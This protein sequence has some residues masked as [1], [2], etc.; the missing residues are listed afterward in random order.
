[1]IVLLVRKKII[2][3][4]KRVFKYYADKYVDTQLETIGK[5]KVNLQ[6]IYN[7]VQMI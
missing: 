2:N 7:L 4:D 3:L 1:M 5:P 6:W